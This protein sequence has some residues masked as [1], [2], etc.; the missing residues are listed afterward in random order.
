M[1]AR[2]FDPRPQD[3]DMTSRLCRAALALIFGVALS[4]CVQ[5]HLSAIKSPE[6]GSRQFGSV[7]VFV[8]L[9]DLELRRQA[10][11]AF[12]ALSTNRTHFVQAYT[13]F[14][15]GQTYSNEQMAAMLAAKNM[16]ATLVISLDNAGSETTQTAPTETSTCTSEVNGVCEQVSTTESGGY[17]ISKPWASYSIRLADA[18]TGQVVW[19]ASTNSGGNAFSSQGDLLQSVA[20]HAVQKLAADS[21][22]R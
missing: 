18:K 17:D 7:V 13:I 3:Y 21:V 4:G 16:D 19:V 8:K 6:L 20:Q 5:T 14:F 11:D 10:E 15:P 12:A 1:L 2:R 9:R 22:I